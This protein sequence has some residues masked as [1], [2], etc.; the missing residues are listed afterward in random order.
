MSISVSITVKSSG[1]IA[2]MKP[3]NMQAVRKVAGRSLA[4]KLRDHFIKLNAERPNKMG[5]KRTNFF[6]QVAR[7]IQ[8]PQSQD[9]LMIV[10]INQVGFAQ[11]LF[12]GVIKPKN[13]RF[14]T[15]P[16]TPEAYGKRAREFKDL[17]VLYNHQ[18]RPIGLIQREPVKKLGRRKKGLSDENFSK[19]LQDSTDAF[20]SKKGKV[21]F[22]FASSVTQSADPTIMPSEAELASHVQGDIRDYLEVSLN[23]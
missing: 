16:A 18:G 6:L 19:T 21:F 4:N 23:Q 2:N 11:R 3:I 13:S 14:L 17:E 22:W 5:G 9:D 10:S 1:P 15:I 20:F 12:G 8:Q 7:S